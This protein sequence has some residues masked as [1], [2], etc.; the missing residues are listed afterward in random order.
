MDPAVDEHHDDGNEQQQVEDM[1]QQAYEFLECPQSG[2]GKHAGSQEWEPLEGVQC[3]QPDGGQSEFGHSTQGTPQTKASLPS[4]TSLS[5]AALHTGL[6]GRPYSP[7]VETPGRCST[8]KESSLT[9][10]ETFWK[11]FKAAIS[12]CFFFSMDD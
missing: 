11:K 12:C 10:V 3:R 2:D 8:T 4:Q 5:M 7:N 6:V 1:E 9:V